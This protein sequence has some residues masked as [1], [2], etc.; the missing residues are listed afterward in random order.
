MNSHGLR[1]FAAAEATRG[2]FA[3]AV[4][5]IGRATQQRVGK[6]QV[7]ALTVRAAADVEDFYAQRRPQSSADGV[8]LVMSADAKGV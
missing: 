1:R 2:S 3:Q 6:R 7:E 8:V 5:A 4:E